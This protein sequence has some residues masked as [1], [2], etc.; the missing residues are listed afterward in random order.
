MVVATQYMASS[1]WLTFWPLFIF[2]QV[3]EQSLKCPRHPHQYPQD[4]VKPA[5]LRNEGNCRT[6]SSLKNEFIPESWTRLH[7][8]TT[9]VY[10]MSYQTDIPKVIRLH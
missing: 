7:T 1:D 6:E 4:L 2:V 3:N 10:S 8:E 5:G 9:N